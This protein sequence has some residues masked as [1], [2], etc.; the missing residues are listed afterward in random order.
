MSSLRNSYE[1]I[2]TPNA[3]D[4]AIQQTKLGNRFN[5]EILLTNVDSAVPL[6]LLFE[7]PV[8][9]GVIMRLQERKLKSDTSGLINFQILWDYD[10]STAVKN[11]MP[12]FNQ[13]NLFRTLKPG[14]IEVSVLNT[15]AAPDPDT[16]EVAITGLATIIDQ[17]VQREP[18]F[19]TT[20]GQGS[21]T[22]GD[23]SPSLGVRDY[24]P[25][26][27]FLTR[28]DSD[29]NDNRVLWGYDWFEIPV[30]LG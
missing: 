26:T 5:S 30:E 2:T 4:Y 9:S 28:V 25:G 18:D 23:I 21:N 16:N 6:F 27:G 11:V 12:V 7:N 22:S 14:L 20:T 8:D 29:A 10:V 17:G 15:I 3:E 1:K 13:N 24:Y 19:I